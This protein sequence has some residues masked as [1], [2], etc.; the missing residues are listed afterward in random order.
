MGEKYDQ[1]NIVINNIL[2][3]QMTLDIITNERISN[4]KMWKNTDTKMIGQIRKKSY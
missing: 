3:L 2:S 4:H 1:N